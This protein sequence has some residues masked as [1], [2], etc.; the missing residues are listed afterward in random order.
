MVGTT[1]INKTHNTL[2]VHIAPT[3]RQIMVRQNKRQAKEQKV[4]KSHQN[5]I[6][7]ERKIPANNLINYNN[8][9]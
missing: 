5:L 2:Q 3:N 8:S 9:K 4:R 7:L 1:Q 6:A